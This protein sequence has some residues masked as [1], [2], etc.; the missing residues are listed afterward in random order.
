MVLS[1]QLLLRLPCVAETKRILLAQPPF[2]IIM[3]VCFLCYS[4][5]SATIV[6]SFRCITFEDGQRLLQAGMGP[7]WKV[8][9]VW[10]IPPLSLVV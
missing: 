5:V 6:K 9:Y 3:F 1:L 4:T 2:L 10:C 8:V 7:P